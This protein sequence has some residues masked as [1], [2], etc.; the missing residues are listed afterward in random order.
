MIIS[1]AEISEN[2]GKARLSAIVFYESVSKPKQEIFFEVDISHKKFLRN[3]LEPFLL[4][5]F[6]AALFHGEERITIDGP[7]CPELAA[8]VKAAMHLQKRW[9]GDKN[10]IP[11]IEYKSD[12]ILE[13]LQNKTA[14]F[15]SGGVDSLSSFCRNISL[16]R[17]TDPRRVSYAMFVY[18]M[19]VGDPNK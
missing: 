14:C 19:D 5:C 7:I 9:W 12:Q 13:N 8:N 3:I 15:L 11:I 18:G 16:Y 10:P 17:H 4:S 6:P 2:K 1:K